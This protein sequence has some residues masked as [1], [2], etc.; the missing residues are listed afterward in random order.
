MRELDGCECN[1]FDIEFLQQVGQDRFKSLLGLASQCFTQ[2][3]GGEFHLTST[4][5]FN[6]RHFFKRDLDLGQA[7]NVLQHALFTRFGQSNCD[8]F[9]SGTTYSSNTVHIRLGSRWYVVVDNVG[10]VINVQTTS[11]DVCCNEQLGNA[12]AETTHNSVAL[13]LI[14]STVKCFG[15]VTATI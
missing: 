10:E 3:L 15:T 5:C 2:S 4:Q 7:L 12:R 9:A 1:L 8:A 11:S 14:H 13:F 6:R